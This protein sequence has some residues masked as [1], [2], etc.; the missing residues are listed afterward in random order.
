MSHQLQLGEVDVSGAQVRAVWNRKLRI[1]RLDE[2]LAPQFRA[3]CIRESQA[4]LDAFLDGLSGV[5]WINPIDAN[6]S[7]LNKARQMRD[8]R[9][10]GLTVPETLITNDPDAV[11]RFFD[12]QG[13]AVVTKM[14][15]PLSTSMGKAPV[16]VRTSEVRREDL[17]RLASLRHCPMVFQRRVEKDRELRVTFV[18]GH[19]FV[20]GIDASESAGGQI[21][22][23]SATPEE[24]AWQSDDIP[25]DTADRVRELMARLQL[26]YGALDFIRT[27]EGEL[28]FLEVNPSGE[29]GMLERDLG[30]PISDAIAEA[31]L[32]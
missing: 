14:L 8:A 16:F 20:G 13:G 25:E 29:W 5:K 15:T 18:N 12:D 11:H 9:A 17:T 7:A 26:V 31:L 30:C 10:V 23:R 19:F 32:A 27:P 22:W 2:N 6:R 28:V 21:D 3:G 24:C 1:P 4:A